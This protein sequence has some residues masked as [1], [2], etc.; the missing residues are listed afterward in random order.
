MNEV[1][2][3]PQTQG[4]LEAGI[5]LSAQPGTPPPLA[6]NRDGIA[7]SV[8]LAGWSRP[9]TAGAGGRGGA[10]AAGNAFTAQTPRLLQPTEP[11]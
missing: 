9:A 8:F 6:Q 11:A 4:S 10:E 7:P 1:S 3:S 5:C 2:T